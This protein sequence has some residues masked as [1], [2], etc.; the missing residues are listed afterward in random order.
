[1]RLLIFFSGSGDGEIFGDESGGGD[2]Y[3]WE[4]TDGGDFDPPSW[5]EYPDQWQDPDF[6]TG[7]WTGSSWDIVNNWN[8]YYQYYTEATTRPVSNAK[9]YITVNSTYYRYYDYDTIGVPQGDSSVFM[10][11]NEN[12]PYTLGLEGTSWKENDT[13]RTQAMRTCWVM[14]DRTRISN[15]KVN[16]DVVDTA[17][18]RNPVVVYKNPLIIFQRGTPY[19]GEYGFD[20]SSHKHA[21][22]TGN[23]D[24]SPGTEVATIGGTSY[25]VPWM[26]IL[27]GKSHTIN[28]NK[29]MD[30]KIKNDKAFGVHIKTSNNSIKV[31][32]VTDL[33]LRFAQLDALNTLTVSATEWDPASDVNKTI[34]SIYAIT[35]GGDT[36]GKLNVS[37]S[38]PVK[39][40]VL[41][42]YVNT[43]SG[44]PNKVTGPFSKTA[45]LDHLNNHSHNQFM[46]QWVLDSAHNH[47]D[48][49]D[50]TVEYNVDTSKFHNAD[51]I[52]KPSYINRFFFLHKG[53]GIGGGTG[54]LNEGISS[55]SND[56]NKIHVVFIFPISAHDAANRG[57]SGIADT[58]GF[59]AL[60]FSTADD[61]TF[62]HE[63]GHILGL[64]HTFDAPYNIPIY[65]TQN[66]MDYA[67]FIGTTQ[68]MFFYCQWKKVL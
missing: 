62:A 66:I 28:L 42:V 15:F 67:Q 16:D 60:F 7:G 2:E 26:S 5:G 34:G 4:P 23:P 38:K 25:V 40:K 29:I 43:G 22:I 18:I 1:M 19:A 49:L 52:S 31:N 68:N 46:R 47:L 8:Y 45:I 63:M 12:S 65:S 33:D 57:V 36:I 9:Y 58:P 64:D 30:R 14:T 41:F 55:T 61:K 59:K 3:G 39:K 27:D 37:C 20:D 32:G 10:L 11:S 6:N 21:S 51:T 53:I 54:N 35:Y 50:L 48:T 56:P 44:Y 17:L 24:F 13:I